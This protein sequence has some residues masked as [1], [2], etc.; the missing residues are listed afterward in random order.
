VATA[1]D[2]SHITELFSAFGPVSVR[3]MFGGAGIYAQGVMFALLTGDVVYL[4]S[5]EETGAA[6][7]REGCGP[8]TYATKDGSHTITS[9]RR[10]PER[11]YDDPEELA[12]WAAA[13]LRVAE[14]RRLAK[15]RGK[16]VKTKQ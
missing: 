15:V 11:L 14:S 12:L 4:K 10:L 9:Y 3:R 2:Y 6:F 16:R 1:A 7:D 13:A 5:S 8:F